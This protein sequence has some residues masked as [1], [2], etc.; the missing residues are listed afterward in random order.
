MDRAA[1][2]AIDPGI[3]PNTS[4]VRLPTFVHQSNTPTRSLSGQGRLNPRR[5]T[6]WEAYPN[7]L[8]LAGTK[9]GRAK[10]G[11]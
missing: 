6:F 7:I 9:D 10:A 3:K 5:A 8:T 11:I 2:N 4:V 1:H